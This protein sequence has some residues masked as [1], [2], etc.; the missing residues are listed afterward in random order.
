[1]LKELRPGLNA[2]F[3]LEYA[4]AKERTKMRKIKYD[5]TVRV[6]NCDQDWGYG[7]GVILLAEVHVNV[8]AKQIRKGSYA[9]ELVHTAI[10]RQ[11]DKL[12]FQGKS[13]VLEVVAVKK[14]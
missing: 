6:A 12:L 13:P 4:N 8:F 11:V 14:P 10:K 2:L 1:M 3:G 5:V 7:D 9:E